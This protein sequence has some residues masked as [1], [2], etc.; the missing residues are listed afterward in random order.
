MSAMS[1]EERVKAV[2][3]APRLDA[4]GSIIITLNGQVTKTEDVHI[5]DQP[6]HSIVGIIGGDIVIVQFN[7]LI[8][9]GIYEIKEHGIWIY[10]AFHGYQG[11]AATGALTLDTIETK[12]KYKGH[13][14]VKTSDHQKVDG[15]FDVQRV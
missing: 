15:V 7:S 8:A 4:K 1:A 5:L 12:S 10:M 2:T 13:F 14:D 9:P 11:T 3:A 6:G